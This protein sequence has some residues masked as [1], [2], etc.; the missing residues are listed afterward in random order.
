[1]E[2]RECRGKL[3]SD[4][5]GYVKMWNEKPRTQEDPGAQEIVCDQG[6]AVESG[7]C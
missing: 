5:Q 4:I 3:E 2:S 7:R 6:E 1:M